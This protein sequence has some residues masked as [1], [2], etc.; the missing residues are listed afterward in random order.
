MEQPGTL[1]KKKFLCNYKKKFPSSYKKNFLETINFFFAI[2]KK[3]LCN[4][5]K[6]KKKKKLQKSKIKKE[7]NKLKYSTGFLFVTITFTRNYL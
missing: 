3:I 7:V 2:I 6:K 1:Y 5:K 4:N